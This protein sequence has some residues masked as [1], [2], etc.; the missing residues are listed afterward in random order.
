M[1]RFDNI[2]REASREMLQPVS[3]KHQSIN[4]VHPFRQH[5]IS[6]SIEIVLFHIS[7]HEGNYSPLLQRR[8]L[9][10]L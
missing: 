8:R 3:V 7:S 4:C 5:A 6:S 9:C 2:N 1:I 10:E